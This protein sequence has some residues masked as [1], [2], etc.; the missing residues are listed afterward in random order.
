[1]VGTS[2]FAG[3]TSSVFSVESTA[4]SSTTGFVAFRRK[5]NP[6]FDNFS[7]LSDSDMAETK[8][9]VGTNGGYKSKSDG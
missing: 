1:M 7:P 4:F 2:G 9:F 3:L 6:F 5:K 8:W